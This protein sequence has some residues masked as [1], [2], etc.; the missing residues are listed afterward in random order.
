MSSYSFSQQFYQRWTCAPE[1]IRSAIIQELTDITTLLQPN[2]SFEDFVF[3]THDLDAHLDEL[4]DN[5]HAEEAIAKAIADK[6]AAD[7][8]E[9]LRL[10]EQEQIKA[11]KAQE[12]KEALEAREA[13]EKRKLQEQ[14]DKQ[15][16]SESASESKNNSTVEYNVKNNTTI[17]DEADK[18]NKETDSSDDKI[19][20][21]TDNSISAITQ[22]ARTHTAIHLS[23]SDKRLSTDHGSLIRELETSIDDYVSEQMMLISENLKSWMRAEVTQR[24]AIADQVDTHKEET[25]QRN[26]EEPLDDENNKE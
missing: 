19:D 17:S 2:T 20:T 9:A 23:L 14:I 21:A 1:L 5:H 6:Q 22:N 3:D 7:A 8:A 11:K 15:Q 4:Y 12:K 10:E 24:L 26:K 16:A 25:A 13:E 18:A